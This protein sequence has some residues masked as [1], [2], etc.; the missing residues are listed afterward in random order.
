MP[1]GLFICPRAARPSPRARLDT[2]RLLAQQM[3]PVPS[4]LMHT[5]LAQQGWQ[6]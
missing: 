1:A 3:G 4:S 5:Q 6:L 2:R